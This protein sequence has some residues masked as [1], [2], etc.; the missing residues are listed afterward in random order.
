MDNLNYGAV[1]FRQDRTQMRCDVKE[2]LLFIFTLK[3]NKK[4]LKYVGLS[5]PKHNGDESLS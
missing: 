5:L 3:T 1:L 2:Y 4:R